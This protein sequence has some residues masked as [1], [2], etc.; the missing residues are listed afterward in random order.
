MGKSKPFDLKY[1]LL[2]APLVWLYSSA[3]IYSIYKL[4]F[5]F[6]YQ[7]IN[8]YN[9][10]IE[11]YIFI[12]FFVILP[13]FGLNRELRKPSDYLNFFFY[14]F[15]YIPSIVVPFFITKPES[16]NYNY[17]IYIFVLFLCITYL[18][19]DVKRN[20]I[21]LFSLIKPIH[22]KA[23]NKILIAIYSFAIILFI[24]TFGIKF[25]I[26]SLTE[27]YDVR[28]DYKEVTQ[29]NIF[30]RYMVGWMGYTINIF[31]FLTAIYKKDLKLIAFT[32]LF[33]FYI[34][35]LMA[36]KTHLGAMLLA[37][38]VFL[39]FRKQQERSLKSLLAYGFIFLASLII[40]DI[41]FFDN[42][43]LEMLIT[44]RAVIIPSQLSYYHFEFFSKNPSTLWGNSIFKSLFNYPYQLAPPNL[45]GQEYFNN[46][47][48]TAVVG[49]FMEGYTAFGLLGVIFSTLIVKIIL[50]TYDYLYVRSKN[51]AV[52]L[53]MT[54]VSANV[55]NSTSVLTMFITHGLIV[56][57]LINLYYPWRLSKFDK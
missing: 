19:R 46:P 18:Q 55:F 1:Y 20:N 4:S 13:V 39:F 9:T 2:V 7:G 30:V 27:V 54:F 3:L 56:L 34:F 14:Y 33:Q 8:F 44:R 6:A 17:Y 41:A 25:N 42:S 24:A 28:A 12:Y 49:V 16:F 45:I 5:Y 10:G 35:S 57:V 22:P 50:N 48:M 31:V 38:V 26:P 23:I 51:N 29:G 40:I 47:D 37:F 52:V 11:N 15:I 53:T 43:F 21:Y 32:V 36:L